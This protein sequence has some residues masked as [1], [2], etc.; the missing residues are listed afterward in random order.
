MILIKLLKLDRENKL[1]SSK[2]EMTREILKFQ[3]LDIYESTNL[4][5][6]PWLDD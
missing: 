6:D 2:V 5:L 4:N 1:I 3:N